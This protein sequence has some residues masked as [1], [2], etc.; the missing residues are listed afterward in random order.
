MI[1]YSQGSKDM[2]NK[3]LD[4]AIEKAQSAFL[5]SIAADYPEINIGDISPAVIAHLK[6][7]MTRS[8]A[9]LNIR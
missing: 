1:T 9:T 2:S 4:N 3:R 8:V 6:D 7:I 5:K